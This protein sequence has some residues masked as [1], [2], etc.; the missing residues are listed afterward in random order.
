LLFTLIFT[1]FAEA[2]EPATAAGT[3]PVTLPPVVVDALLLVDL[4][5]KN[6][7]ANAA[8]PMTTAIRRIRR[9]LFIAVCRL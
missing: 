6:A 7:A 1:T 3:V 8:A 5:M 2:P 9:G 4:A